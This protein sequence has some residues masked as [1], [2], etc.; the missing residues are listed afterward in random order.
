MADRQ[1]W[2]GATEESRRLAIT[3]D[4]ELRRRHPG[5]KIEPLSSAE[6][7]LVH[8]TSREQPD[9]VRDRKLTE[10]GARIL[11]TQ[12]QAFR[13]ETDERPQM[14]MPGEDLAWGGLGNAFSDWQAADRDAILK[15]P[16]PEIIPAAR[17]L[18]HAIE[19]NIEP[20]AAD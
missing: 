14:L 8:D 13:A 2:E 10:M 18:R 4:A 17:I 7:A 9:P 16:K 3:A 20:E 11:T 6:P 19:H 1:E 12:H 15:P 5:Q